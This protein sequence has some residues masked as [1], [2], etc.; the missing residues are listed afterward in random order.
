MPALEYVTS[1]VDPWVLTKNPQSL[2]ELSVTKRKDKNEATL[3]VDLAL[4]FE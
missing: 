3:L 2:S 1:D 4:T